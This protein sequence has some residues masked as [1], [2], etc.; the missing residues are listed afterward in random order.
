MDG[1]QFELGIL[2]IEVIGRGREPLHIEGIVIFWS[3]ELEV[4]ENNWK[5]RK[6]KLHVRGFNYSCNP[7][8]KDRSGFE[9][10]QPHRRKAIHVVVMAAM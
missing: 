7:L 10:V 4:F 8:T 9:Y 6:S 3:T 2:Y 5:R 1:F